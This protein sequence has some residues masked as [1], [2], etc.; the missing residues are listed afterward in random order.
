MPIPAETLSDLLPAL[1]LESFEKLMQIGGYR[2]PVIFADDETMTAEQ[3]RLPLE[4]HSQRFRG[5]YDYVKRVL[6]DLTLCPDDYLEKEAESLGIGW[7]PGVERLPKVGTVKPSDL[8]SHQQ[9]SKC[10]LL[11]H[12]PDGSDRDS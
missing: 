5:A 1:A 6:A 7:N 2:W 10:P 8:S 4:L 9:M 12:S 3:Y 11:V